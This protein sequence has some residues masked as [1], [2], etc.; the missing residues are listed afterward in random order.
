[1]SRYIYAEV[2]YDTINKVEA[3]VTAMKSRLDN[4]PTDWCVVKPATSS[5]TLQV[6]GNDIVAYQYGNPLNDTQINAL[7]SSDTVY[8]IFSINEGDNY[9]AVSE[10]DVAGK[11]RALRKGYATWLNLNKYVDTQVEE[12]K[13]FIIYN[14][15]NEDM[16]GYV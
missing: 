12:G 13:D 2:A 8:N 4:N 6:D 3:A 1:M 16:S 9:T 10:A 11:V 14:V 5:K 7:S 15:T